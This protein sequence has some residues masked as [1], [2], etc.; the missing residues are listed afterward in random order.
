MPERILVVEDEPAI[1]EAV[2]YALKA[3]GFD[4]NGLSKIVWAY[5]ALRLDQTIW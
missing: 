2:E 1:A 3:E 4:A 5:V